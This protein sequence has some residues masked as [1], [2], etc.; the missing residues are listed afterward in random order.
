MKKINLLLLII[1]ILGISIGTGFAIQN[2]LE[3]PVA[4]GESSDV[5]IKTVLSE[6]TDLQPANIL[7]EADVLRII[8]ENKEMLKGEKGDKG[9]RGDT[10][11][12]GERGVEGL[13][14]PIGLKGLMGDDGIRGEKG[15][16]G[17]D[18]SCTMNSDY[19]LKKNNNTRLF[20]TRCCV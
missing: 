2:Q 12:K 7:T 1:A 5:Q 6:S 9:E 20:D 4:T 8:S 19:Y 15:D 11:E 10:G 13:Q 3:D 18:G 17:L 16:D 14:G